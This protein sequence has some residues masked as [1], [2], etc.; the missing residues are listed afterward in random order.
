M[1]G[2]RATRTH[3]SNIACLALARQP[4]GLVA[5]SGSRGGLVGRG[6]TR[7]RCAGNNVLTRSLASERCASGN[8]MQMCEA[9]C[10]AWD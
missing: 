2:E 7:V 5:G 3:K 8:C 9:P 4:E 10:Q 6:C 1:G